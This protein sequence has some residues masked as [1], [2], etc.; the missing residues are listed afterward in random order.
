MMGTG[1]FQ[2]AFRDVQ[3]RFRTNDNLNRMTTKSSKAD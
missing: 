3:V 2:R 1:V